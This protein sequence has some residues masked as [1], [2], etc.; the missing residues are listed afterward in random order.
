VMRARSARLLL[1]GP[2]FL[3]GLLSTLPLGLRFLHALLRRRDPRRALA[4]ATF[5][6]RTPDTLPSRRIRLDFSAQALHPRLRRRMQ[7]TQPRAPAERTRPGTGAH[8]Q[9]ILRQ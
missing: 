7:L 9:A 4:G 3:F 8:P 2:F 1:L 5:P 6:G